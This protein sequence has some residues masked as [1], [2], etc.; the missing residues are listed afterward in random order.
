MVKP[1]EESFE[2]NEEEGKT[3][4]QTALEKF[5]TSPEGAEA[6]LTGY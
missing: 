6:H 1:E 5:V 2:A 3:A 4:E